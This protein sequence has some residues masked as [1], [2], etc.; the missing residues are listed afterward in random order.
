MGLTVSTV[1]LDPS[2]LS[3]EVSDFRSPPYANYFVALTSCLLLQKFAKC[4]VPFP[5]P[6]TLLA[7]SCAFS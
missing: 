7:E 6:L 2:L 3:H 5:A 1:H 4:M